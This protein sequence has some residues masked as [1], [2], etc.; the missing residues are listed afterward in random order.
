MLLQTTIQIVN[1][2]CGAYEGLL[3]EAAFCYGYN[4]DNSGCNGD[5]GS[6]LVCMGKSGEFTIA[7]VASWASM[8]CAPNTPTGF[9]KVSEVIDWIS[10][11]MSK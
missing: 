1:E 11:T 5:S 6:P 2:Y 7:G 3:T 4:G 8:N 10:A 9:A